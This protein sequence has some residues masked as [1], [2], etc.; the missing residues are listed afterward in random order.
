MKRFHDE[1]ELV[2]T[3]PRRRAYLIGLI[4]WVNGFSAMMILPMAPTMT[5]HFFP[6]L[7]AEELGIERCSRLWVSCSSVGA[8]LRA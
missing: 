5:R 7:S 2:S 4:L 3:F 8:L 1:D 6:A